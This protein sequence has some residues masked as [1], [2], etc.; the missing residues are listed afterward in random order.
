MHIHR[1]LNC[2]YM[3]IFISWI[4][5]WWTNII[6]QWLSPSVLP[7]RHAQSGYFINNRNLFPTVL[8]I[9]KA[10]IKIS[11]F[12]EGFCLLPRWHLVAMSSQGDKVAASWVARDIGRDVLQQVF[13]KV[14]P[15]GFHSDGWSEE[16]L[17]EK[18]RELLLNNAYFHHHVR[19]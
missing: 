13:Y 4:K 11:P 18:W 12:G 10:K 6:Y 19:L 16:N 17:I 14:G 3:L 8:Q 15:W 9:E 7:E 2:V 1:N 5:I